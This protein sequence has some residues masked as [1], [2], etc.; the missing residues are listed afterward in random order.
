MTE[1][2]APSPVSFAAADDSEEIARAEL[3]G[4][5]ARLAS[6]GQVVAH[7]PHC[8]QFFSTKRSCG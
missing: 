8:T 4:L 3:Y 5:L 7:R 2:T 1:S 6:S